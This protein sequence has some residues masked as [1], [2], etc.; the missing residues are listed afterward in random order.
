MLHD[1]KSTLKLALGMLVKLYNKSIAAGIP[2]TS[3]VSFVR[4]ATSA[5]RELFE[6]SCYGISVGDVSFYK[7]ASETNYSV[8]L[9]LE[10]DS[11]FP[12]KIDKTKQSFWIDESDF[13]YFLNVFKSLCVHVKNE[14]KKIIRIRETEDFTSILEKSG[15]RHAS[16]RYIL[17]SRFETSNFDNLHNKILISTR[18]HWKEIIPNIHAKTKSLDRLGNYKTAISID[19]F[20]EHI[21]LPP[22]ESSVAN[23]LYSTKDLLASGLVKK[24]PDTGTLKPMSLDRLQFLLDNGFLFEPVANFAEVTWRNF[25][26]FVTSAIVSYSHAFNGLEKLKICRVCEKLFFPDRA[27][28][29]RGVYCSDECRHIFYYKE[30]INYERCRSKHRQFINVRLQKVDDFALKQIGG[31]I[32]MPDRMACKKCQST[33]SEMPKTGNC[34][35]LLEDKDFVLLLKKY[36]EFKMKK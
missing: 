15:H 34:P 30:N 5:L 36:K 12:G 6:Q 33:R 3:Y 25:S 19:N 27:G 8:A 1:D 13:T 22:R 23:D 29:G 16:K 14:D 28:E 32:S 10:I 21:D 26:E 17:D 9:S 2:C 4:D 11:C 7:Y 18:R 24:C 35:A 31:T 20:D